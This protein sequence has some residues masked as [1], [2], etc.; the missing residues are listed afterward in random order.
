[1]QILSDTR[2]SALRDFS[3]EERKHWFSMKAHAVLPHI[4]TLYYTV[5]ISG[6]SN[7]NDSQGLKELIS[8]LSRL[9]KQKMTNPAENVVF[10]DLEVMPTGFSI[11]EFQLRLNETF[12]I[13]IGRYLPN[14]STPRVVVQLRS[15]SLVLDGVSGAILRSYAAVKILFD[16]FGL[17][18]G[19]VRENRIDYAYHTNLIQNPYR[20][21]A[22]DRLLR[23]LRTNFGIGQKVFR[24][25]KDIRLDYFALGQKKSNAIFFRCYN[26]SQEVVEKNYKPFFIER[27]LENGLISQYDAYVYRKAYELHSYRT[28]LLVGRMQWYIENGKDGELRERFQQ[29][30]DT[31]YVNSDNNE[32]LEKELSSVLPPVTLIMNV[33]FQTKRR[34]YASVGEQFLRGM[35]YRYDGDPALE[36]LMKLVS[37]S[38]EFL[39]YLTR[40]TI[41][42]VA[43][44][45]DE[46]KKGKDRVMCDWWRRI[47]SCRIP[48]TDKVTLDLWR[49]YDRKTDIVRSRSLLQS[50]IARYSIISRQSLDSR[51]FAED[52]S[53]VLCSLN[54]NDFYG[55]A[56]DK[57][58]MPV[59]LVSHGYDTI[60]RRKARQY[61][62]VIKPKAAEEEPSKT[63]VVE[64]D[65]LPY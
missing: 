65:E 48:F 60:Q 24:F 25:G 17:T 19:E 62:G 11:Y 9:K 46:D 45:N 1:M 57:D 52:L 42:F 27:W 33:E 26:K 20:F 31:G 44:R 8:E 2:Y 34:F 49:E 36:K 39:E 4:D 32:F 59:R 53:D 16:T 58:G 47:H 61:R 18:V 5:S 6:D 38:P 30:L 12:D 56:T 3:A 14:P 40:E 21:F 23:H 10:C 7:E 22:D 54:D 35:V 50:A 15:R 13:F 43:D 37:L 55:F 51:S 64:D 63:E 28:G 41:C 29:D